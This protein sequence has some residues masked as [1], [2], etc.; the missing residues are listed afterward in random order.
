MANDT[1]GTAEA[2]FIGFGFG[3]V[4][5]ALVVGSFADV[6]ALPIHTMLAYCIG[7]VLGGIAGLAAGRLAAAVLF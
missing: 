5:G 3:A 7:G 2:G 1:K 4:L 6:A